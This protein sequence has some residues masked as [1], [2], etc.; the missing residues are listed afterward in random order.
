MEVLSRQL[1]LHST[2]EVYLAVS[3]PLALLAARAVR[4]SITGT[5]FTISPIEYIQLRNRDEREW[6]RLIMEICDGLGHDVS[7][8][9]PLER[10]VIIV[11]Q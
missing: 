1:S 11:V 4:A 8:D 10:P 2:Q 9:V 5:P 7:Y 3:T 6:D